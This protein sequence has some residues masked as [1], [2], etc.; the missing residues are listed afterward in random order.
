MKISENLLYQLAKIWPSPMKKVT[1]ILGN[2]F[3]SEEYHLNYALHRQY[4]LKA[5]F[6]APYDFWDKN[7]LEIGCGHGGISTYLAVNGAKKVVGIDL[8]VHDLEIAKKFSSEI[9]SRLNINGNLPL[10]FKEMNA[11][12]MEFAPK[13]FDLVLA[14]NVFEH[15]MDPGKVMEQSHKIL[16][17]GGKLIVPSFNSIYSKYGPHLKN[18]L[19]MPWANVFFSEK[20]ICKVMYKLAQDNPKLLDIYP[21]ISENTFKIKDLRRY[22]DLNSITHKKF[23]RLAKEN[24]FEIESFYVT[25]PGRGFIR[26]INQ[27]LQRFPITRD[28]IIG[29]IISMNVSAVLS[30]K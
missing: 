22:K 20:T 3:E 30:K 25:V 27:G 5:K 19:K 7:I 26:L 1:N 9:T 17:D 8:N 10:E 15:F 28:S 2:D 24:G 4:L 11:Y 6:G 29:E 16:N 18:G 12:E 23:K 21:G 13:S 14:D